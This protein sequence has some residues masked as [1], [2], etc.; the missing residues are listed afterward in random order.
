MRRLATA[1]ALAVT[2]GA[3]LVAA[4]ATGPSYAADIAPMFERHCINCHNADDAKGDLDLSGGKGYRALVG[5][6]SSQETSQR[7]VVPGDPSSS[8]LWA[9]LE[10]TTK[11]GKGMPRTLFGAKK[12][13][14]GELAFD[15]RLRPG[16]VTH[17]NA[18]ALMHAVGLPVPESAVDADPAPPAGSRISGR[19]R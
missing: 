12:L 13:D 7:L 11:E 9:K 8:Y 10:H 15:Y 2:G 5:P 18:L 17:S 14:A 3:V 19:Q 6:R 16:T 1:L 4:Q